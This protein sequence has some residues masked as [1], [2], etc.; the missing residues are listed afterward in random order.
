MVR[1][2]PRPAPAAPDM[3]RDPVMFA[4]FQKLNRANLGPSEWYM[5]IYLSGLAQIKKANPFR[6]S[7]FHL[8]KGEHPGAVNISPV[9]MAINTTK[10]S[11]ETLEHAGLISIV[12]T[13]EGR[14]V[15]LD[16]TIH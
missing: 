4:T 9:R 13:Q 11:L 7:I 6:T 2:R 10:S 5:F 12:R 15:H 3:G 1:T 16:I 14:A 8:R